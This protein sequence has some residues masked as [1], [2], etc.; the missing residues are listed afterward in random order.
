MEGFDCI[1]IH[2]AKEL[3]EQGTATIVDVRDPASYDEA[4]IQN[5]IFLDDTIIENF[6]KTADKEKPLVCYC[7]HGNNSQMAALFFV[8]N[9]F[10]Q[11]YSIDGG[12]EA[13]RQVYPS[14]AGS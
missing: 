9:G 5:A 10:K 13:W 7:Y 1:D 14:V 3:I 4:H 11:T 12:F 2:K 6:I 8:E